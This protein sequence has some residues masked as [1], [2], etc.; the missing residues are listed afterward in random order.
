MFGSNRS[1][2]YRYIINSVE[3]MIPKIDTIV[4]P[5]GQVVD[6]RIE[7]DFDNNV[8]PII[9][10]GL[11]L[12]PTDIYNILD[13][14]TTVRFKLRIDKCAY[15]KNDESFKYKE[16]S[17]SSIFGIYIDD[18][19]AQVDKELYRKTKA[20]QGNVT[21]I[22]DMYTT[23]DFFL[24]KDKDLDAGKH[25]VNAVLTDCNMS[26]ILAYILNDSGVDRVLMAQPDNTKKFNEILLP[27]VSLINSIKYIHN[28]YG[29]YKRGLLFFMDTNR[30]YLIDK[31]GNATAYERDE[32]TNVHIFCYKSS[33]ENT[34]AGGCYKDTKTHTYAI[35]ISRSNI[36][37]KTTSIIED[38]IS[39]TNIVSV[40]PE[41][42][43]KRNLTP[44][45]PHRGDATERVVVNKYGN[46]F[47][48]DEYSV[49]KEETESII[50]TV[51][52]GVDIDI[53]TPNKRFIFAFEDTTVQ[54]RI[55]GTYRIKKVTFGF[56]K[57]GTEFSASARATFVKII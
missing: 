19:N 31:R 52:F 33:N 1:V 48:E 32:Y 20:T 36:D 23:Y 12:T 56:S 50:E 8:F 42:G 21:D 28:V 46:T 35:N 29:I 5:V 38:Q 16:N 2:H 17:F 37:M 40:N 54:K 41:T 9:H 49:R 47:A 10:V 34:L 30:T 18:N 3:I 27:P 55:G 57:E 45:V 25:I 24:F 44:N 4:V 6:L 39:T 11:T 15:N 14:K 53:L 22:T 7:K 43:R 26:D 13:N 51:F